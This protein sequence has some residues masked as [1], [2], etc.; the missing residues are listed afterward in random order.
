MRFLTQEDIAAA[1]M[2]AVKA[3]VTDGNSGTVGVDGGDGEGEVVG[4]AVSADEVVEEAGELIG[5]SRV[6]SR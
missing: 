1:A 3:M 5:D 2:R 6:L 4:A